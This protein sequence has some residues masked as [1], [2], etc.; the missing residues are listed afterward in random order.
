[1]TRVSHDGGAARGD[2]A[3]TLD[4]VDILA[5]RAETA[6]LPNSARKWVVAALDA[7]R[8]QFPFAIRGIDSENGSEFIHHHRIVC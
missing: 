8:R 3:W 5:G 4:T 1:L 6:A 7:H 2:F